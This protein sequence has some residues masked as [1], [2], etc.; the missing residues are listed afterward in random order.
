MALEIWQDG[1]EYEYRGTVNPPVDGDWTPII[2]GN[3]VELVPWRHING[4]NAVVFRPKPKRH[5]FG[6]VVFEETGEFRPAE[7]GEWFLCD[8]E[9]VPLYPVHNCFVPTRA[10]CTILRPAAI[11]EE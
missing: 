8:D 5:K 10:Y 6:G 11:E 1:V 4:P 3:G 7:I 2:S 9:G